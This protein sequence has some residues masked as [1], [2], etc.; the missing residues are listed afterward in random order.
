M[1]GP[2]HSQLAIKLI[3]EGC[4]ANVA[5]R[6][7]GKMP[8]DPVPLTPLQRADIG[9]PQGGNT[10][11]YPAP[12][13]GVF[14]DLAGT[15]ATVWYN[16]ADADRAADALDSAVKR[17]FPKAKQTKDAEHPNDPELRWRVYEIDFGN[18]RLALMEVEY[19]ARGKPPKKFLA[20]ILPQMR[21][22]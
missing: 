12:P 13:T 6:V 22:Q 21:K 4:L 14:L 8:M 9:L 11:F 5:G 19:P 2:T 3:V 18:S 15:V 10:V 17:A 1:A 7:Q 16:Q 20:R